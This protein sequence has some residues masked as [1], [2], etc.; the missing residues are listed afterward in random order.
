MTVNRIIRERIRIG[1]TDLILKTDQLEHELPKFILTQRLRLKNY[2]N[3]H[4]EFL[5]S[6]EPIRVFGESDKLCERANHRLGCL[7]QDHKAQPCV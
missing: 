6:F 3:M 4:P 7:L 5:I 2:I 1:E